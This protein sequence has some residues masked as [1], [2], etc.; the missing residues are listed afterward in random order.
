MLGHLAALGEAW[1]HVG[2]VHLDHQVH[3]T[4]ILIAGCGRVGA[5]HQRAVDSSG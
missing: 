2:K 4:Q 1:M 3:V 5:H